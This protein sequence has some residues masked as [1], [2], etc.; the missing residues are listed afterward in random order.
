MTAYR[1]A[2][3]SPLNNDRLR[4]RVSDR[5]L[6][7][8][9]AHSHVLKKTAVS[10]NVDVTRASPHGSHGDQASLDELMGLVPHDL[11]ILASARLTL[12]AIDHKI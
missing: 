4:T 8:Q 7:T 9:G 11:A 2:T 3:N 1:S 5:D 6:K 10:P 12:I